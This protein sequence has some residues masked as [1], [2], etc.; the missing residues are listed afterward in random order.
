MCEK[1]LD[2]KRSKTNRK[3]CHRYKISCD[4]KSH[5]EVETKK[6]SST[7]LCIALRS[8]CDRVTDIPEIKQMSSVYLNERL[9]L[10]FAV[11][12]K[13]YQLKAQDHRRVQGFSTS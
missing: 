4:S 12:S 3:S 11:S 5:L 9:H 1:L 10:D 8:V 2:F 13:M 7:Q 6:G